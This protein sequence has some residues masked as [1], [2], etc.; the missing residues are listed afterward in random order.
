MGTRRYRVQ[1]SEKK[2][3]LLRFL[4]NLG[5]NESDRTT[6]SDAVTTIQ[7]ATQQGTAPDRLHVPRSGFRRA[8]HCSVARRVDA[9][10]TN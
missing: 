1:L 4:K 5:R 9:L 6:T 10:A 2:L 7:H 8:W 3:P